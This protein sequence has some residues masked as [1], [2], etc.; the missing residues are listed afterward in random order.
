M[1]LAGLR[2]H[3]DTP[4]CCEQ[5]FRSGSRPSSRATSSAAGWSDAYGGGAG[6]DTDEEVAR[7][8]SL[9]QARDVQLQ[10]LMKML[11]EA[12]S[13]SVSHTQQVSTSRN[14]LRTMVA[15]DGFYSLRAAHAVDDCCG[16]LFSLGCGPLTPL[17]LLQIALLSQKLSTTLGAQEAVSGMAASAPI[18]SSANDSSSAAAR[19]L[20]RIDP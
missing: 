4:L 19:R 2:S 7:L 8:Q 9:L 6:K 15:H 20:I 14:R 12:D 3:T 10:I 13:T 11:A 5:D 18:E 16:R 1:F 17:A